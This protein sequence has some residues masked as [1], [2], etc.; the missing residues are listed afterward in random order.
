MKVWFIL[1]NTNEWNT[2]TLLPWSEKSTAKYSNAWNSQLPD[3]SVKSIDFQRNVT[4]LEEISYPIAI[5]RDREDTSDEIQ[6]QAFS[7]HF[8]TTGKW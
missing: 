8:S 1:N 3:G 6:Y 2:T 4:M 7:K 5:E